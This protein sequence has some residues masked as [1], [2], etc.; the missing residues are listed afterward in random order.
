MNTIEQAR[1]APATPNK[2]GRGFTSTLILEHTRDPEGNY[3]DLQVATNHS[4][5][6]G[7]TASLTRAS[8]ERF[9]RSMTLSFGDNGDVIRITCAEEQRPTAKRYNKTTA[10]IFH[11]M[12]LNQIVNDLDKWLTW[13]EQ[14][15]R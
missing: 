15:R 9:G 1:F 2:D 8:V 4:P 5:Q 3:I 10:G 6:R 13:A 11:K 14:K 7:Y 12:I